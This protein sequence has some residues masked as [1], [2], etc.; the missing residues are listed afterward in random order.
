MWVAESCRSINS[1]HRIH[2]SAM[3]RQTNLFSAV[4][5]NFAI[6]SHSAAN[7][8][9]RSDASI[10]RPRAPSM[11]DHSKRKSLSVVPTESERILGWPVIPQC[12]TPVEAHSLDVLRRATVY[13]GAAPLDPHLPHWGEGA[14]SVRLPQEF[15]ESSP[16]SNGATEW[17]R[18]LDYGESQL[19]I[20]AYR[21]IR[22]CEG[23]FCFRPR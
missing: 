16:C 1:A 10:G 3:P 9:N 14:V 8:R 11:S 5:L 21:S 17:A 6:S 7:L 23:D 4:G 22:R 20:V 13:A 18:G 15:R 12:T 2:R 19:V